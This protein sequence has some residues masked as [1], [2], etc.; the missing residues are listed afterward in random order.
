MDNEAPAQKEARLMAI[1]RNGEKSYVLNKGEFTDGGLV[2]NGE[3]FN[4]REAGWKQ[5]HN[6]QH[7][8]D[9]NRS[10]TANWRYEPIEPAPYSPP[11]INEYERRKG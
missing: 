9:M 1:R 8:P 4:A 3:E 10:G 2:R 7:K 5:A 11:R 6:L